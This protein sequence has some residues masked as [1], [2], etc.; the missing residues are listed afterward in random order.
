MRYVVYTLDYFKGQ[1]KFWKLFGLTILPAVFLAFFAPIPTCNEFLFGFFGSGNYFG[2][3]VI[4]LTGLVWYKAA[5][6]PLSVIVAALIFSYVSAIVDR[7]MHVGDFHYVSF[8]RSINANFFAYAVFVFF[9]LVIL[10][11]SLFAASLLVNLW[12]I[13]F[14]G[15]KGWSFAF[16][17]ITILIVFILLLVLLT[18]VLIWPAYMTYTGMKPFGAIGRAI[19]QKQKK[20]EVF[21]AV[22]LP[23]AGY[24]LL[25]LFFLLIKLPLGGALANTLLLAFLGIYLPVLIHTVYY[26]ISGL[27]REDLNKR[28]IWKKKG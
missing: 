26:D 18:I 22:F 19:R 20:S 28:S 25:Y 1:N 3:I 24:E 15:L 4:R 9:S 10:I 27:S 13:A 6:I 17:L 16:S 11:F 8:S 7:D 2:S 5:L 12:V 21:F 23:F 14:N